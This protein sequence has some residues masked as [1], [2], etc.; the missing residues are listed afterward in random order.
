M[1]VCLY[2]CFVMRYANIIVCAPYCHL[3]SVWLYHNFLY[4]L[5]NGTIFGKKN[6]NEHKVCV[7]IFSVYLSE[8][9]LILRIIRQECT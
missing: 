3:R 4:Y 6:I 2:S 9:F 5:I 8:N 7:F 1:R